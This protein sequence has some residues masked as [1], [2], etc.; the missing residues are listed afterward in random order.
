MNN[1]KNFKT[2]DPNTLNLLNLVEFVFLNRIFLLWLFKRHNKIP[3]SLNVYEQKVFMISTQLV[4]YGFINNYQNL[5][6][7]TF[8]N[9]FY[10]MGEINNTKKDDTIFVCVKLLIYGTVSLLLNLKP[11]EDNKA[12][13]QSKDLLENIINQSVNTKRSNRDKALDFLRFLLLVS[14]VKSKIQKNF[15]D[16][17]DTLEKKT[18]VHKTKIYYTYRL[19][20]QDPN[21][22]IKQYYMGYRGCPTNPF[23][24]AYYSSSELVQNLIKTNGINCFTKK[25][26][27]I[28]LTQQEAL[29][30]EIIYHH[31]LQVD[32]N[33]AFLNQ[34]RQTTTG[35]FYDPTGTM[36][37]KESNT[38]RSIALKNRNRFTPEGLEKLRAYQTDR[39]RSDEERDSLRQK[40]LLRNA[41]RV[42]CPHCHKE[43]QAVAMQRWHFNNCPQAPNQSSKTLEDRETLRQRMIDLNTNHTPEET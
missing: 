2:L 27:G 24:D 26:L 10:S 3:Q 25:I 42:V 9:D 32:T 13:F 21:T 29:T 16:N 28:Y 36:Q 4:T 43:G 18:N 17:D 12:L 23:F 31:T 41:Q 20:Y 11:I 34:A 33:P 35:F 5:S 14:R 1:T 40:A 7:S 38:K 39:E 22:N 19:T 8:L 15:I 37:T 30:R 6:V